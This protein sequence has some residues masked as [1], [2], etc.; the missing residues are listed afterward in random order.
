M[1]PYNAKFLCDFMVILSDK[2]GQIWVDVMAAD[3]MY[4]GISLN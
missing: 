1:Q 4:N 2:I 3:D